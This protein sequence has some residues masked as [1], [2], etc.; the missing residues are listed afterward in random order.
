MAAKVSSATLHDISSAQSHAGPKPIISVTKKSFSI[1]SHHY[2]FKVFKSKGAVITLIWCFCSLLV[3]YF[4]MRQPKMEPINGVVVVNM[5]AFLYPILGWLGDVHFGRYKMMKCSVW[6]MWFASLLFCFLSILCSL[7]LIHGKLFTA[8]RIISSALAAFGLGG[9]FTNMIPFGIDQLIDASS[10]EITSFIRWF[11][12]VWYLSEVVSLDCICYRYELV[13]H[14]LL[15]VCLSFGLCIDFFFNG[16]LTKAPTSKNP[17]TLI[18]R[19]LKYAIKNKYPRQRSAF[20]YWDSQR[21]S[22]INLG[23]NKYGGPFSTEE[24]ESVKTF[25]RIM[26]VVTVITFIVG[27]II[28]TVSL[29]EDFMNHFQD[30]RYVAENKA[31]GC[32]LAFMS[33]CL[34]R[35]AV[36]QSG[37]IYMVMFIPLFEFTLYPIFKRYFDVSMMMKFFIGTIFLVL[38]L[39]GYMS[40]ELIGHHQS[41]T[42]NSIICLLSAKEYE[43]DK[44]LP[45]SYKWIAI[46]N[47]IS[48]TAY[49]MLLASGLEFLC[50]QSPHNMKGLLYGAILGLIGFFTIFDYGL[51]KLAERLIVCSPP[52]RYGC[53]TWYLLSILILHLIAVVSFFCIYKWYYWRRRRNDNLLR[54]EQVSTY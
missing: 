22:R 19:V 20:A 23:K 43:M 46:P 16:L 27:L 17:L 8:I 11:C 51:L 3:Y 12:W 41:N 26:G 37:S 34:Q 7:K 13:S 6:L 31:N 21:C 29:H 54:D 32:D 35:R 2:Q 15:P 33:S 10:S 45:L 36:L 52:G 40:L 28:H 30:D 4:M 1:R 53:G 9:M 47:I 49:F 42:N 25:W 5:V 18:F 44:V 38:G 39:L 50:S 24:V 14:L 48:Y